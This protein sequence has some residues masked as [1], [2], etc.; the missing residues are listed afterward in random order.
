MIYGEKMRSEAQRCMSE[1]IRLRR[2]E[3]EEIKRSD[4][5]RA[6]Y[7]GVYSGSS[8]RLQPTSSSVRILYI[9]VYTTKYLYV[10]FT[11]L[12]HAYVNV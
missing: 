10:S 4:K 1:L 8:E 11:A 9:T 12:T 3:L 6:R 7:A 2:T 5:R